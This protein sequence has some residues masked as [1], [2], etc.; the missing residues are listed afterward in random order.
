M[1][2]D[3]KKI[4]FLIVLALFA[5]AHAEAKLYHNESCKLSFDVPEGCRLFEFNSTTDSAS[6]VIK[7]QKNNADIIQINFERI[8]NEDKVLS[9]KKLHKNLKHEE[10]CMILHERPWY[11]MLRSEVDGYYDEE[12][13]L[14]FHYWL[15]AKSMV[16][17]WAPYPLSENAEQVITSL[18]NHSTFRGKLSLMRQNAGPIIMCIILSFICFFGFRSRGDKY[19]L[20]YILGSI[21]LMALCALFLWQDKAVM[22]FVLGILALIW[23]FF[24]SHN[25]WL[26]WIIDSI[27]D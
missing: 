1:T 2:K 16:T 10:N 3:M 22:C 23:L 19:S 4:N 21:V 11:D 14:Y 15:K 20:W 5:W 18:D 13:K 25:K 6:F 17:L 12:K 9:Y 26:I 24:F 27:F 7:N 8:H